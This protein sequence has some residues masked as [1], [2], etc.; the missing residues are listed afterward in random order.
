MALL[1]ALAVHAQVCVCSSGALVVGSSAGARCRAHR[2]VM[3]NAESKPRALTN[4]A[5]PPARGAGVRGAAS[6]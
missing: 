4:T 1:L 6:T 3:K 2:G 5:R